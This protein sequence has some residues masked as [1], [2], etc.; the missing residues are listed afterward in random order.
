MSLEPGTTLLHYKIAD[1]IGEGGM[2]AVYRAIDS[3]LDRQVALK[4][5]PADMA[6]DPHRLERFQREARAVAALNH[7]HIVTIHGVEQDGDTHF[8][9]M[10]Q[11][12][13]SSV[14]D[15]NLPCASSATSWH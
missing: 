3:K 15:N 7:P 5:L 9:I 4:I 13:D 11:R 2:G 14:T 1:K 8:L 12:S 6:S 10:A